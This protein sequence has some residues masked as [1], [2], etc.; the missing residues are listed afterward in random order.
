MRC[1]AIGLTIVLAACGS[2]AA[3][4]T[5][6]TVVPG[7]GDAVRGLTVFNGSC[8]ACHGP[9]GVGVTG[10]GKPLTTSTFAAGLSDAELL[11][12][13]DLGRAAGDPLNTTGILMPRRGGN[14]ALTDADLMD[15]I[16]FVRTING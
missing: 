5:S 2:D 12:F 13:L 1:A 15:V 11:A 14:P 7:A 10:L 16:A 4:G 3:T 8:V 9:G 6:T